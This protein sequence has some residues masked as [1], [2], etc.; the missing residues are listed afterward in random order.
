M[1]NQGE[2]N[3]NER[4]LEEKELILAN[5]DKSKT[6]G[7]KL[8]KSLKYKKMTYRQFAK[9]IDKSEATVSSYANNRFKPSIKMLQKF[10]EILK[11]PFKEYYSDVSDMNDMN[12]SKTL[13]ENPTKALEDNVMILDERKESIDNNSSNI[14]DYANDKCKPNAKAEVLHQS[15]KML[16]VSVEKQYSNVSDETKII[17]TSKTF[18]KDLKRI[19]NYK[20]ITQERFAELMN[21]NVKTINAYANDRIKPSVEVLHKMEEVLGEPFKEYYPHIPDIDAI[22]AS[23]TFREKLKKALKYNNG[24]T[25][26]ELADLMDKEPK[27][28]YAY[29]THRRKPTIEEF[30]QLE[31]ILGVSFEEYYP[32]MPT[33]ADVNAAETLGEKLRRALIYK[34]I[35]VKKLA[36]LT[37]RSQTNIYSYINNKCKPSAR[38][39]YLLE[40]ILGISFKEYYLGLA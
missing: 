24:M 36:K 25:C 11:I 40:G 8:K 9:L 28:V 23:K 12:N 14:V 35:S 18:G 30:H 38:L 15:E 3:S 19:L 37:H 6:L 26:V 34:K 29:T 17:K 13:D 16:E 10:E 21:K 1:K 5:L 22:N 39:L 4:S 2:K 33:L 20:G 7:E 27:D 31:E 32:Y